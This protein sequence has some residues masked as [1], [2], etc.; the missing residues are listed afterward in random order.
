[1]ILNIVELEI[2]K[3][4]ENWNQDEE[5]VYLWRNVNNN[6]N[7]K[8]STAETWQV[9]REKHQNYDW[10]KAV[11]FKHATPKYSFMVWVAMRDRL[12]TGSIMVQWTVNIDTSCILCQDLM[13]TVDHIFFD[14]QFSKQIWEN[15]DRGVLKDRF[16]SNWS[17]IKRITMDEGQD[18]LLLFTIRY[19]FQVTIQSIWREKNRRRHGETAS[20]H[21]LL[22]KLID[23]T[24]RN[25]FSIIQKKGDK[26]L[27][28]GLQ[29]WFSTR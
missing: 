9:I 22:T 18:K 11:W 26:R 25:K 4:K 14:C 12:S 5:D 17:A 15:L 2:E 16:T 3:F 24:M 7:S 6:F 29:F 27:E 19:L 20:P 21:A 8:F 1:M 23:K 28:G 13:E 10:H